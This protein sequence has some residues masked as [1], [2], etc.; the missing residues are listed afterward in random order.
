MPLPPDIAEFVRKTAPATVSVTDGYLHS[1]H[2]YVLRDKDPARLKLYY[3]NFIA[4]HQRCLCAAAASEGIPA[5][6]LLAVLLGESINM[7][8]DSNDLFGNPA[9]GAISERTLESLWL[10][11]SVGVGQITVDT[12]TKRGLTPA[13]VRAREIARRIR[14]GEVSGDY[15]YSQLAAAVRATRGEL[16]DD[17]IGIE[18]SATFLSQLWREATHA[19]TT[20]GVEKP[21]KQM[22]DFDWSRATLLDVGQSG[23]GPLPA[24]ADPVSTAKVRMAEFFGAA[25]NDDRA[26]GDYNEGFGRTQGRAAAQAIYDLIILG[27]DCDPCVQEADADDVSAPE[28]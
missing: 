14:D 23:L 17:C 2:Y 6:L 24:G 5:W 12:A 21:S 26:T 27:V 19:Y 22:G 28:R 3:D 15:G 10:G 8:N 13:A 7:D 11:A 16:Q 1:W 20:P 18:A 4:R 9:P 25:H